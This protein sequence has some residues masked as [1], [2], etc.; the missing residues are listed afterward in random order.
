MYMSEQQLTAG[1]L[2]ACPLP[3]P[4]AFQPSRRARLPQLLADPDIG[5]VEQLCDQ[6]DMTQSRLARL[7]RSI[8]GE[9][10]KKLL[11]RARFGRMLE[12]L[13]RH[14]Y[15]EWRSFIDPNYFDQSHFIRDFRHF[16]GVPPSR[17]L[18][19]PD[20]VQAACVARFAIGFG[21]RVSG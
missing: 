9:T 18:A 14:P 2:F 17:Y 6:L 20:E 1:N 10:P 13:A 8:Y 19:L 4:N 3:Q 12:A 5:T 11:R 21:P 7:C 15:A 16:L